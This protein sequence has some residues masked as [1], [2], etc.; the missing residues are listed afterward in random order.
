MTINATFC[1]DL[2]NSVEYS[3]ILSRGGVNSENS[4]FEMWFEV[5][6]ESCN[7]LTVKLENVTDVN[8]NEDVA[9][10]FSS[11]LFLCMTILTT[12]G[13][14]NFSPKS[15]WGK[16][17]CIFYGFVGIPICGV[18]LASTSDYFSNIFL[19]LYEHRQKKMK[20]DC[21]KRRSIFAAAI[22]F[23]IPGFAVFIFFPAALFVVIEGWSYLDATYFCFLTL[24]TVGFGDIVA[25]QETN[26]PSLWFYRISWIIWVTLGIA[27]W[28]IVINFITKALKSKKLRE[29]WTKTS[30]ALSAQAQ[31]MRRVVIRQLSSNTLTRTLSSSTLKSVGQNDGLFIALKTKS[32]FDFA[33]HFTDSMG[34]S[35]TAPERK[36]PPLA[37]IVSA[38]ETAPA[39]EMGLELKQRQSTADDPLTP[40]ST[41]RKQLS[42]AADIAAALKSFPGC[43]SDQQL[44][45]QQFMDQHSPVLAERKSLSLA[46]IAKAFRSASAYGLDQHQQDLVVNP[47]TPVLGGRRSLSLINLIPS[48]SEMNPT[49]PS[50]PKRKVYSPAYFATAFESASGLDPHQQSDT[51]QPP[52][53]HEDKTQNDGTYWPSFFNAPPTI[54]VTDSSNNDDNVS[55]PSVYLSLNPSRKTSETNN[56]GLFPRRWFDDEESIRSMYFSLNPSRKTS[57]TSNDYPF[58]YT[59]M[60]PNLTENPPLR[61]LLI[62]ALLILNEAETNGTILE[63][64]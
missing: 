55:I 39:A 37:D 35:L 60:P 21:D 51:D 7:N 1:Q 52:A 50:L 18:F 19:Y 48:Q 42:F 57:E 9:W 22:F 27:Y 45:H 47:S 16:V 64:N 34:K 8:G 10:E 49:T 36:R 23:L 15:N 33:L 25:A 30:N 61:D 62:E 26:L 3:V 41:K 46:D 13:Y 12:I 24:T 17:F 31:E 56:D 14:G 32:A 29:K 20:N 11:A 53:E 59:V 63:Q 2:M 43:E 5:V 6:R 54:R 38:F 58:P 28:A 40:D 44:H 4:S